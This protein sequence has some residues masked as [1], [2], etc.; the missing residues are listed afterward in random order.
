MA[1][2]VK[3]NS[4]WKTT[5]ENHVEIQ[6]ARFKHFPQKDQHHARS[7]FGLQGLH[8]IFDVEIDV[9]HGELGNQWFY[10]IFQTF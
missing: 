2:F 5:S 10:E 4:R 9:L 1:K 8:E 6:N 3:E 7:V